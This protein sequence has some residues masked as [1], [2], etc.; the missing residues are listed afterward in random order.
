MTNMKSAD[1][2]RFITEYTDAVWN[3]GDVNAI[4][5]FYLQNYRHHDVS[6]PDVRSLAEYKQWGA[7]LMSGLSNL[8]VAIDDVFA[9]DEGHAVKRWTASGT[10]SAPL[11]GI[12]PTGKKV[13]FEGVSVYRLSN[14]RIAESWYVYDLLGLLQQ[15]GVVPTPGQ[16]EV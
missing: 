7:D 14:G 16:V 9:D 3:R 12:P 4:D 8:R 6:R 5:R 2:K 15:L 13:R 1:A 11:A 10:H